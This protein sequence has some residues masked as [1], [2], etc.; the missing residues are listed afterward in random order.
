MTMPPETTTGSFQGVLWPHDVTP[1]INLLVGGSPWADSIT[2][3]PT[4]RSSVAFPTARPDRPAWTPEMGRISVTG[5][6]DDAD[7][8]AVA[9]LATIIL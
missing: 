3:Y 8:V 1:V 4:D 2:R 6:G 7:I 5:L 9:K